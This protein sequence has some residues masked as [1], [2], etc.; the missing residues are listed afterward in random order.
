MKISGF[1]FLRNGTLMGYPYVESITSLL[2]LVDE[3]IVNVGAGEDDTLEQV[4]AISDPKIKVI[5]ST[6]N[7][8][9]TSKGFVYAQQKMI[10]QYSCTG[11]WAFY[12]EGDEVLHEDDLDKIRQSMQRHLANPRVEALAFS[13]HHLYGTPRHQAKPPAWCRN[14]V[15]AIRTTIRNYAP[16]GLF[17]MVMNKHRKGRY[18]YAAHTGARIFHYGWVRSSQKML[19]KF[20]RVVK[21]WNAIPPKSIDYGH[22]DPK[23][24]GPFE[25]THPK[26]MERWLANEAEQTLIFNP[27]YQLTSRNRRHR[28]G[29]FMERLLGC[30]L[31]KRH[32]I[33]VK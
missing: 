14:E 29:M 30:D 3:Y 4:R 13:Y 15:R 32:Y 27:D 16:D 22:V 31:S 18:P 24:I 26:V 20:Q 7:E 12:L 9:L 5:E 2:P 17:W 1:T 8:S 33:P 10:A 6:W 28:V 25:G 11:D 19:E 21:Y 23:T